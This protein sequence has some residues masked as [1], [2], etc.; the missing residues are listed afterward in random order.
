[1]KLLKEILLRVLDTRLMRS[2][3][4]YYILYIL[5]GKDVFYVSGVRRSGNHAFIN[6][7]V[8]ALEKNQ[9]RLQNDTGYK[10]FYSSPSGETIFLNEV[11]EINLV[12]FLR[13]A[14]TKRKVIRSCSQIILSVEDCHSDYQSYKIP[15]YD[16]AIYIKRPVLNLVASRLKYL[17]KRAK[18]GKSNYWNAID[19]LILDKIQSFE[20]N[21]RF[22]IWEFE[23]WLSSKQYRIHFLQKLNL[24]TSVMPH[25]STFGEGSSFSATDQVP[26]HSELINRFE[27][28]SFLNEVLVHLKDAKNKKLLSER[29]INY[30]EK[31]YAF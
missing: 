23:K 24:S 31:E 18:K 21:D 26:E 2:V 29:E 1:M 22:F 13:M 25:I 20:N 30:L 10:Y 16:R 8:N 9:T 19:S 3:Y 7:L 27:Q 28:V 4:R 14:Y 11:N 15:R 5:R 17:I 6:W 12:V